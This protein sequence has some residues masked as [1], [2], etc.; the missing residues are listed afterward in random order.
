MKEIR[1]PNPNSLPYFVALAVIVA[2]VIGG[3]LFWIMYT[4]FIETD[5]T[6]LYDITRTVITALAALS[7][8]GAAIIQYRK[9]KITEIDLV[10]RQ[11]A[12]A[13]HQEAQAKQL[14]A[15]L[16]AQ[17]AQQ[18]AQAKQLQ[19]Q[20][21]AQADAHDA[22]MSERLSMAIEHLGDENLHIRV[23]ALYELR[24]LAE[25]SSRDRASIQ[26][27]VTQFLN[28]KRGKIEGISRKSAENVPKNANGDIEYTK[29]PQ[30]P[31]DI[32][33]AL[34]TLF[35]LFE[36]YREDY[37]IDCEISWEHLDA[38]YLNLDLLPFVYAELDYARFDHAILTRSNLGGA[39]LMGAH[40]DDT[41]L[42]ESHF[43]GARLFGA[44]FDGAQL[45]DADFSKARKIATEQFENT[46]YNEGTKFPAGFRLPESA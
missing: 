33:V 34:K 37:D 42:C 43:D 2:L 15:Q 44:H 29:L 26:E 7:V 40:F 5:G 9:H 19:A 3:G 23:G 39:A 41:W 21:Q 17:A 1:R 30:L 36:K 20:L 13:A 10:D 28:G 12:Q 38:R 35:F 22:K 11:A 6:T 31:S 25:D 46:Q 45:H 4:L 24:R 32:T 14:Q 16:Q 27:I 8:G 18:E